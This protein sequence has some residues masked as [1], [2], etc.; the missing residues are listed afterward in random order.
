M[1][2]CYNLYKKL[3]GEENEIDFTKENFFKGNEEN[4]YFIYYKVNHPC[5]RIRLFGSKYC[6]NNRNNCKICIDFE[7]MDL[8]EFYEVKN[9]D[10]KL[11]VV[12]SLNKE[13]T[14]LSY[15]FCGC[16]MLTKID[17][18]HNLN[19]KKVTSLSS[20]FYGCSSLESLPDISNWNTT[21]VE[22]MSYLF[23]ECSSLKSLPNISI[24]E[25]KNVKNM[26]SMFSFASSLISLPNLSNWN[27]QNIEDIS[28]L[29]YGCSS[30]IEIP[31]ISNWDTSKVTD[32]SNIFRKCSLLES[33]PD[34]SKWNT[35]KVSDM[36]GIFHE[37]TSLKSL[38]PISEWKTNNVSNMS[39]MFY[40]C[41]SLVMLPYISKWD[42]SSVENM[43]YMF[44]GCSSLNEIDEDISNWKTD[45]VKDIS[46]MFTRCNSLKNIPN[47]SNW[48]ICNGNK[49]NFMKNDNSEYEV[50]GSMENDNLKFIPQII[51][52][53]NEV[54][55]IKE[56]TISELRKELRNIIGLENFSIIEIKR[57]SLTVIIAL[58]FLILRHLKNKKS[59]QDINKD[60]NNKIS[61]DLKILSEKLKNNEFISL[62]YAK[63]KPN[64]VDENI[65]DLSKEENKMEI[66]RKI[67]EISNKNNNNDDTN[68]LQ[69]ASEIKIKDLEKF[70]KKLSSDANEQENN[71]K[72][73]INR[74]K[75]NKLFD[76][77]VEKAL[78]NSVF[79]YK[80]IHI[81]VVY[82]DD[83]LY[84]IEKK[85]CKNRVQ[86]LLFHGTNIDAVTGILS[87]QFI[88]A[89]FHF[90]GKGVYFTDSLDY[91]SYYARKEGFGTIPHVG[92]TF[93]VVGSE[94]YYDQTKLEK[95][96][97]RSQEEDKVDKNAVRCA[98]ANCM[99]GI[100]SRIELD[101]YNRF[102]GTEF[103]I[104]EKSQI[105]PLYGITLKR[106]EYLIIWRDIN[107]D[108]NN[109][110]DFPQQDFLLMQEF[111]R[112]IRA[113]TS[114]DISA[115]IYRMLNDEDAL[116]LLKRKKYN[117]II[118]IT[119]GYNEGQN[120]ILKAR[121]IIGANT[122]AAVSCFDVGKHIEWVKK[123]EN[124]LLLNGQEFHEKFFD[125]AKRNDVYLY[126]E[127]RNEIIQYYQEQI[128]GFN[129]NEPTGNLFNF[130]NFKENGSFCEL[131]FDD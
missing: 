31:D 85:K 91:A 73:F 49:A 23:Y 16:S 78:R 117:K 38:S 57:G 3:C 74:L 44:Y 127:L 22:D 76:E 6:E 5:E 93:N 95:A 126:E 115:K 103:L 7:E 106:V 27:T 54:N 59:L 130:P 61:K 45:K 14:D 77:E 36:S 33:L 67:L 123:M 122:I 118:I 29:F 120:F 84:N 1:E 92:E 110:N 60:F 18:F 32:I 35:N 125:C 21:N 111:H 37:C 25:T 72:I 46:N 68:I 80:I 13:V 109:L 82:K 19:F 8:L 129:L 58:Q 124:V 55:D 20:M 89:R 83:R 43:S 17:D 11:K 48:R 96:Y 64:Y 52:K 98:Y 30:L 100:M 112:K 34:I 26:K 86:K 50:K 121:D 128:P 10:N 104:T 88:D 56:N 51:M 101:G 40:D 131:I 99:A 62:G 94:I 9:N 4:T 53:F 116:S 2:V 75:Y 47:I 113:F 97:D 108:P 70:I 39:Y 12:L 66:A 105:L 63:T 87:S 42:T 102:K 79:E 119:N 90:I 69:L 28:E 15:I 24:W 81:F 41:S 114:R 71:Q 65:M 107:F